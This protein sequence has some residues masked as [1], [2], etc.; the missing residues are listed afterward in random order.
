MYKNKIN[1]NV[2]TYKVIILTFLKC[3][4]VNYTNILQ[5]HGTT[6]IK[7]FNIILLTHNR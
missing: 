3:Y 5:Y 6:T 7:N 1:Y 4:Y 2:T